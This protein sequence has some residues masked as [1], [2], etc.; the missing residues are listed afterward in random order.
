MR[1]QWVVEDGTA[2]GVSV[3]R[4]VG[5]LAAVLTVGEAVRLIPGEGPWLTVERVTP[6]AAYL[7]SEAVPEVTVREADGSERS[8]QA[9]SSETVTVSRAAFVERR[10]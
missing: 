4:R 3:R 2:P 5:A 9:R 6:C 7:R 1:G 10:A 8:F